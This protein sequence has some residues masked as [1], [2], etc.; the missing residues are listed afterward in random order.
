MPKASGDFAVHY[1]LLNSAQRA[2]VNHNTGPFIVLAGAGTGKTQIIALRIA[3]LLQTTD[4]EPSNIL[5]LTFT[6]TGVTAMRQRLLAMIG[7]PA[8]YV[9]IHTFHSFCNEVIQ[10]HPEQF[11]FAYDLAPLSDI[12]RISVFREV[13][14]ALPT[15]SVLKPFAAPYY[16]ISDLSRAIQTLKRENITVEKYQRLLHDVTQFQQQYGAVLTKFIECPARSITLADCTKL[17]KKLTTAK[18]PSALLQDVLSLFKYYPP[19]VDSCV[20]LHREIKSFYQTLLK[21]ILKQQALTEVYQR[22]QAQLHQRGRYDYE[23]ML[24]FVVKAWQDNPALLAEYQEL[25]Q[26]ILVDEYQDTNGAQNE[27]VRLLGSAVEQPNIFVVGDDRQSIYRFQG[28]SL[29]NILFFYQLYGSDTKIISLQD[30]YRS[31]QTILTAAESVIGH[32]QYS[33]SAVLPQIQQQLTAARQLTSQPIAVGEFDDAS[34]ELFWISRQ[35]QQLVQ[36]GILANDIAIIYRNNADVHELMQWLTKLN[37]PFQVAAGRNV[38][39][40]PLIQQLMAL[41]HW[42]GTPHNEADLF[43]LLHAQWWGFE[44]LALTRLVRHSYQHKINL[45]ELINSVDQ[46]TAAGITRPTPFLN[47]AKQLVQWRKNSVHSALL[48]FMDQLLNE[49]GIVHWIMQQPN[50]VELLNRLNSWLA[51]VR[52]LNRQQPDVTPEQFVE[53]ISLLKQHALAIPEQTLPSQRAAVQL[54]TAHRAKG[55]EFEHVFIM[56]CIDRHWGNVP[57]RAKIKLPSGILQVERGLEKL[58]RNEDERRLFYV[59]LTRAKQQVYITYAKNYGSSRTTM[60]A[61]FVQE[62]SPDCIQAIDTTDVEQAVVE[63]LHTSLQF[64]PAA[65]TTV[66]ERDYVAAMVRDYALSATHLNTYLECPRQF[67]Y[68]HLLHVPE[69]NTRAFS[70]GTAVHE[71]LRRLASTTAEQGKVPP[72]RWL[73]EQF[74]QVLQRQVLS[75][76]QQRDTLAFGKII[77]TAYYKQ[78]HKDF[79]RPLIVEKDFTNYNVMIDHVPLVGKIDRIEIVSEADKTVQVVDYKTG[80]SDN[81]ASQLSP[82]GAYYRQLLFYKLLCD[83]AKQ[84][85]YTAISGE[86]HFI[87]P[88]KHTGQF[89]R[90]QFIFSDDAITTI[91][92]EIRRVYDAI[93]SLA[94]LDFSA[95]SMCGDCRYCEI[96]RSDFR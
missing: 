1:Q 39:H 50:A 28:A 10:D 19:S 91:R 38:L 2:A 82:T 87:Q 96:Q 3:R 26:Y 68:R 74:T 34:T 84:F 17:E 5:C 24:L 22:Y 52:G 48:D 92:D 56:K 15:D 41:L 13:L 62:L 37:I 11:L 75:T 16:Y 44:P 9:K 85:G 81:K 57:D 78:Y 18:H 20:T 32:N 89:I 35:V 51:E 42:L 45:F 69:V 36:Q 76:K 31:Q 40:D 59:A 4:L 80:N 54:L 6:E 27:I 7:Q 93:T 14:D 94:F 88:S 47:L 71:A 67:Y 43:Q 53:Y 30:N 77:L 33:L 90:K 29:E 65:T 25:Y 60:P 61:I 95:D 66:A 73:I 86:V 83:G 79:L 23:D 72:G 70:F 63:R 49:A 55:L 21:N 8:Y 46:L 58:M 12:E 64:V